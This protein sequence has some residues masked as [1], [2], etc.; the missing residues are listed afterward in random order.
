MQIFNISE[1]ATAVRTL[2]ALYGGTKIFIKQNC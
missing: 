2:V 1:A